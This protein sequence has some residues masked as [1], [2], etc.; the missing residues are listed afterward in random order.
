MKLPRRQFLHLAAGIAA[1][2]SMTTTTLAQGWPTRA[3]TMVDPSAPGGSGDVLGRILAPR[4]SE[5]LGRQVIVENIGGAGGMLGVARVAKAAPDGYQ[6][7]LGNVGNFAQNQTFYKKPLYNA[8]MDFAP[9]ALVA[10]LPLV[11]ITRNDFPASNLKEFAAYAKANE[12]KLQYASAG[13]GN[14]THLACA[15]LNATI[16]IKATHVPYRGGGLAMQDLIAGRIDY[17]CPGAAVAIGHIDSRTVKPIAILQNA[18]SPSLPE[19][20]SAQ[21]QGLPDFAASL[22]YA[23]F[24]P[25]GTPAAIV[26]KLHD[27]T[28]ATMDTPSVMQRL[29]EIGADLVAP[30]RRSSQYLQK[31]VES[32]IVKWAAPIKA[33]GIQVE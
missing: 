16:G 6:F 25:K 8:A 11:L 24:L 23:F 20:P 1:L 3:V 32:E 10:E 12:G 21:E 29:K 22:W 2:V 31:F 30:E 4:L 7:V 26:Q 9:V 28:V 18:R 19:L 17:Q 33:A 13:V 5:L 15:L 27:A 14:V